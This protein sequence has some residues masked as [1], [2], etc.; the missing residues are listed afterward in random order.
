M[1]AT[2]PHGFTHYD[3]MELLGFASKV[4]SEGYE[5]ASENYP[6][7][8]ESEALKAIVAD[9]DPR[10]LKN[11]YHDHYRAL[12]AWQEQTGWDQ[13]DRLW[14]AHLRE[15]K[16]RREAHLLWALHPGGG[17]D[18]AAYS[19]AY[20]TREKALEGIAQQNRLAEQYPGWKPFSGRL[21]NRD[22]P[23]GKWTEVPLP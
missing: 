10:P 9:D 17:W 7:E 16:E 5:Y 19:D 11:L 14:S 20:E 8:F 15:Q 18:H 3:W 23:G 1:T 6:P 21:L 22:T 4:D 2:I 13:V 12:E